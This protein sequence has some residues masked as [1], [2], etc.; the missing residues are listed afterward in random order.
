MDQQVLEGA[1]EEIVLHAAELSG[2]RVRLT[3]L[4]AQ[5]GENVVAPEETLDKM[6]RGR[7]GKV[8]FQPSNLSENTGKAFT[9]PTCCPHQRR[10]Q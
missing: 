8:N 2:R 5:Q 1:W 10:R 7:V 6:L 3:I 4:T 9:V